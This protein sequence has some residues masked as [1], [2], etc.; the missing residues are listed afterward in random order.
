MGDVRLLKYGGFIVSLCSV[1]LGFW[2]EEEALAV[3][4]VLVFQGNPSRGQNQGRIQYIF[5][6]EM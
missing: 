1:F 5:K 2:Q 3:L 6:G 4:D